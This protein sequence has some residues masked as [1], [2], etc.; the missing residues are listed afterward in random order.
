MIS[1][2]RNVSC[3]IIP[4]TGTV[5]ELAA[6]VLICSD[7]CIGGDLRPKK[8][9]SFGKVIMRLRLPK[10]DF[11][12]NILAVMSNESINEMSLVLETCPPFEIMKVN[13]YEYYESSLSV[14][15]DDVRLMLVCT[16]W[17]D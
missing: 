14:L 1:F 11:R 15:K 4:L 13:N 2:Y 8:K 17:F 16:D 12:A 3:R 5:I 9:S 10:A 6:P 7:H